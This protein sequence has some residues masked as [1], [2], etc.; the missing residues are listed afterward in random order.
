LSEFY[1]NFITTGTLKWRY[2]I[3]RRIGLRGS[4]EEQFYPHPLILKTMAS[5]CVLY[6]E[7]MHLC[8]DF[9]EA[10]IIWV[11][12]MCED[13]RIGSETSTEYSLFKLYETLFPDRAVHIKNLKTAV[14]AKKDKWE[15]YS[16]VFPKDVL[17]EKLQTFETNSTLQY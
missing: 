11:S 13:E 8:E 12:V 1:T 9:A 17:T 7:R 5:F 16:K 3:Q 15:P 10:F 14:D 4:K 6:R 2:N